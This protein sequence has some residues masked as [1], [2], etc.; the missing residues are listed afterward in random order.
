MIRRHFR[1]LALWLTAGAL[2][3]ACAAGQQQYKTAMQL[4]SAGKYT[5]AIAYLEEA[6]AKEPNNQQYRRDLARIKNLVVQQYVQEGEKALSAAGANVTKSVLDAAK[7]PLERARSVDAANPDVQRL[8]QDYSRAEDALLAEVSRLYGEAKQYMDG[9]QWMEANFNLQQIQSRYPN[10]EN[11]SRMLMT[12]AIKGSDAY[13]QQGK[14]RFDQEDFR[15]AAELLRKALSLKGDHQQAREMLSL[16][17][18]RDNKGYFVAEGRKAVTAREWDRAVQA[19][20]RASEYDESDRDLEQL[21]GQV[22]EKAGKFYIDT[23]RSQLRQ[24]YLFNAAEN[25]RLASKYTAN[26]NGYEIAS[27]RRDLAAAI[28]KTAGALSDSKN[29]GS[30]WYWYRTLQSIDS[31][32]PNIFYLMQA[33]EDKVRQRVRKAIAVFDFNSPSD[34]PDAGIIV[35]NNLITYLFKAASKDI[36]I[37]ERENLKSILEEMKLGQIGVV[38]ASSAKEMGRVYGI[39]VAIMGSVLLYNVDSTATEGMKTV[40]YKVGEAIE[41]NIEFLNWQAKHPNASPEMLAAAPPAKIKRPQYAEKDYKVSK[42][43][44]IGFIQLSFRIVDVSTGENLQ[45][46]TIERKLVAEDEGSAGLKEAGVE[47]DPVEIPTDIELLQKMTDEVVVELG[48]EVLRPLQSLEK[49]YFQEGE[50]L[51]RRRDQLLAAE[52]FV[53]SLFD[54]GL[55]QIQGSPLTTKAQE[56]LNDIFRTYRA[57]I[58]G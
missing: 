33:M 17:Q 25:Y 11:S 35:A 1:H 54:E 2:L 44:K 46:K 9:Q 57:D 51:L 20:Q 50:T 41:D 21:L 12:A 24:G 38:T 18:S 22:K 30:A 58:E 27:L 6:L 36:K 48:R 19:Y 10:Y 7:I 28:D 3:M 5:D 16:A 47:Y 45:V 23:A 43:K 8:S 53:D 56:H 34:K 13:F 31:N 39:D 15:G 37:L 26:P 49:S 4:E 42:V 14:E 40:R 29:Y 55:K 32:Y 52:K